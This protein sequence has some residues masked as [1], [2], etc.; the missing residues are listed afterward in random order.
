M[1][2]QLIEEGAFMERYKKKEILQIVA[3]LLKANQIISQLNGQEA[4]IIDML[5]TC[6]EA[7]IL[8]GT[9][10]EAME[11]YGHIVHA[12]EEY[13]ESVYQIGM[14]CSNRE[15]IRNKSEKIQK[16]LLQ[17]QND[18]EKELP[19][20]KKEIVF[21]P[22]K[23]SMWDSLESVWRAANADPD[24]DA[25]VIP[26]PYYDKNSDGT[27]RE[28]H[29][30]GDLYPD[31]VPITSYEKYDFAERRPDAV[32]IHNPYDAANFVTSVDP[33]FYSDNLKK[34]T[35]CLVYI[36]YY[37]T[38]GGMAESQ[39][40]C[41]AYLHADYIII[42][43]ENYRELFDENLPDEKF[44]PFGSPKFDRIIRMCQN[45]PSIPD[46]WKD[47]VKG[48][49]V[50]FYNTSIGG[51]LE[52]TENFLKKISY[53]FKQFENREDACLLWRPH[54]LLES[55]FVSMRKEYQAEYDALKQKFIDSKLGIYDDT[56]NIENS[57]VLSDAY[58]GDSGTSVTSLFGVVGKPMF[59]LNNRIHQLPQEGDWK[60][61]VFYMPHGDG[62]DRYAVVYGNKLYYS[63]KNDG[64]YQF[65]CDLSAYSGGAYYYRALERNGKV[66]IF[67][68]NAEN[69]L[70][71]DK[72]KKLQ[73]IKLKHKAQRYGAFFDI[74]ICDNYVFLVPNRY[75]DLVRFDLCTETVDYISGVGSFVAGM[76]DGVWRIGAR[77]LHHGK[78]T[79][80]SYD[81]DK[82]LKLDA[83][84]LE[85]Q[86]LPTNFSNRY[87]EMYPESEKEDIFWLLPE[88]GTVVKRWNE[89]TG[90]SKEF[91]L[92]LDGMT[93]VN[94]YTE[95]G[96]NENYFNSVA[97]GEDFA[98]FAPCWGNKFVKL[99]LKT[100][101]VEEWKKPFDLE[102]ENKNDY[103]PCFS[104]GKFYRQ[105]GTQYQYL[106]N[107]ES[108]K[109]TYHVN[110]KTG[111]IQRKEYTFFENEVRNHIFG[112]APESQWMRYCCDED[113]FHT[114]KEF[115]DGTLPGEPFNREKQI[116]EFA[117][118]NASV[119]GDCGEKVYEFV[120]T[121]LGEAE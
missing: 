22:Y 6:Q 7:A 74:L 15:I 86:V 70:I 64:K 20:D 40:L 53:V 1:E 66:Y 114:L 9:K 25:Y 27:F 51:M 77:C 32:F 12:L 36:P 110:L 60:G 69:I 23:A 113:V 21:L 50:Y 121:H 26:I 95:M 90:E 13:C 30:E 79:F 24:C 41:P 101:K 111:E 11:K 92:Y 72:E 18:I 59:I 31:D 106:Y 45:P 73:K 37:S 55:T 35:D 84:T 19:E 67:P 94:R 115:L 83:K 39:S 5:Q 107:R 10:I 65:Y 97:F 68:L 76:I 82:Y 80:L 112:F 44:L 104:E 91:D 49:K 29:Y 14:D 88:E 96:T 34:Y 63:S 118:I 33:F 108:D 99:D 43:Q 89:K 56:P 103:F 16:Q 62:E 47:I 46:G 2:R 85:V 102:K 120:R 87:A 98:V 48:K 109:T 42:Q 105:K 58:I 78:L 52:N 116:A 75:P 17:I 100:E 4:E 119:N 61:T 117:K 93:A 3:N 71:I 54:P 57:I 81:G 8:I 28:L 38:T